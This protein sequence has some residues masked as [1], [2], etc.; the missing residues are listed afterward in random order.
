M[1][2][3]QALLA[4]QVLGVQQEEMV[5]AEDRLDLLAKSWVDVDVALPME[6]LIPQEGMEAMPQLSLLLEATHLVRFP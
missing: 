4:H 5:Q 6:V 2:D 3:R 1:G